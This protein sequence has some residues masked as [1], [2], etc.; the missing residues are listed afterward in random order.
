MPP[1]PRGSHR[2]S[3]PCT[4]PPQGRPLW[5]RPSRRRPPS[6]WLRCRFRV[7]WVTF[8]RDKVEARSIDRDGRA[9]LDHEGVRDAHGDDAVIAL[10]DRPLLQDVERLSR[11]PVE[12]PL[13]AKHFSADGVRD[14]LAHIAQEVRGKDGAG[15]EELALLDAAARETLNRI[16]LHRSLR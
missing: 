3:P 7:S 12:K 6:R 13:I 14:R 4:L 1:P 11:H 10:L 15:M 9:A 5:L 2:R 8:V 16:K